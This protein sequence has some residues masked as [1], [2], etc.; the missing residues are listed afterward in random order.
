MTDRRASSGNAPTRAGEY[1]L[2]LLTG[3]ELRD[4]QARAAADPQFAEEVARWRGRLAPLHEETAAVAPPGGLW[5]RIASATSGP[6]PSNDN[7]AVLRKL[8][9]W[10]SAAGAMTAI[11]ASLA[12]VAIFQARPP[13]VP[14]AQVQRPADTPLVAMLGD[15]GAIKVVASWDPTARQLVLA[16]PGEISAD[17]RHARELW[18]IPAGGKPRSLGTMPAGKQMHLRLAEALAKL[19]QHGATIA[20]SI[21]PPG[22][23]PTGA[24]TGPVIASGDLTNA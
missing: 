11:A 21:E 5:S 16:V 20:I 15:K 22:G 6:L 1:A 3:K 13:G 8:R 23:S 24:P 19:L 10:R 14:T 7:H 12:L 17:T 18:V 4:A 9:L 2:G